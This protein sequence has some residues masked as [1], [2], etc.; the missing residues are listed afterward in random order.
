[1][2]SSSDGVGEEKALLSTA[3]PA[4]SYST[5]TTVSFSQIGFVSQ[6]A[7]NLPSKLEMKSSRIQDKMMETRENDIYKR[8]SGDKPRLSKL[9]QSQS[10]CIIFVCLVVCINLK[11]L[12]VVVVA[13]Q[14]A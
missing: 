2:K 5:K 1:M 3:E 14:L 13:V 10:N 12:K 9:Q 6:T 4:I 11:L 7:N 8:V